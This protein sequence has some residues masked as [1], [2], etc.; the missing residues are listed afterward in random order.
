PLAA[1]FEKIFGLRTFLLVVT[2]LFTCF[3]MYCGVS[4]DL[5]SM[6]IGR[7][8]QGFTGGAM[9]PTALTIV[10]LRLPPREQPIGIAAF[11]LTALIG[12]RVGPVMG[13]GL[14]GHI[15][16][17]SAFF[18]TLPIGVGLLGLLM[19]GLEGARPKW[20]L[21]LEADLLGIV[22]LTLGL[23]ALTCVLEEGEK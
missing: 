1:W 15:S 16:W 21:F 22:G 7:L 3:S 9:I 8:G 6:I 5:T 23:G 10:A 19:I 13:A 2:T 14:P 4:H 20:S 17:H 12:L 11:G 18:L